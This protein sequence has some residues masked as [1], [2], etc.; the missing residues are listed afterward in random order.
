M[1]ATEGGHTE[2]L[3]LLLSLKVDV[4][5]PSKVI[6][7]IVSFEYNCVLIIVWCLYF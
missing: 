3:A 7:A 5:T 4:H 2:T 1:Y 6:I